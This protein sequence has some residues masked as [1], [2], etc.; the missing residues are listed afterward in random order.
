MKNQEVASLL[1]EAADL[2]ELLEVDWKPRAYRM[3]AQSIESLS[4][5]IED[6]YKEEGKKGLKK[7]SGVGEA[8]AM[9]IEEFLK[10]GKV[11]KFEQLTKKV[12]LGLKDLMEVSGL[13]AKRA[14]ILYKKLF[15]VGAMRI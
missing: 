10:K 4:E 6:I 1:Y 7:I 8:I 14:M 2:L 3:A 5:A 9:H 12:P 13:G 15:R 11:K